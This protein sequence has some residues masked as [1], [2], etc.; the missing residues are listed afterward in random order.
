MAPS[1]TF[2]KSIDARIID[3]NMINAPLDIKPDV[4]PVLALH[5]SKVSFAMCHWNKYKCLLC[6][7]YI[8]EFIQNIDSLLLVLLS[9]E[10]LPIKHSKCNDC[11]KN[12]WAIWRYKGCCLAKPWCHRCMCITHWDN[13]FHKIEQWTGTYFWSAWIIGIWL[14]FVN[15]ASSEQASMPAIAKNNNML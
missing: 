12:M 1:V 15:F 9:R 8:L 7:N 5:F 2:E 10:A 11:A 4:M 13:L 3:I 6:K 14:I